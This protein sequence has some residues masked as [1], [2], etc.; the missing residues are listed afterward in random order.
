MHNPTTC[1]PYA[2]KRHRDTTPVISGDN[3]NVTHISSPR[4]TVDISTRTCLGSQF[5]LDFQNV[6]DIAE[7]IEETEPTRGLRRG[8]GAVEGRKEEYGPDNEVSPR[9][10]KLQGTTEVYI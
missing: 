6:F 5:E 7:P 4:A 9:G 10:R 1:V 8:M 2:P 3:E